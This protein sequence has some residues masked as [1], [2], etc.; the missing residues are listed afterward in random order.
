AGKWELFAEAD[1]DRKQYTHLKYP[2]FNVNMKDTFGWG[3]GDLKVEGYIQGKLAATRFFSGQGADKKF[4]LKPDD[5]ELIADGADAT[6]VVLRVTDEFGNI[7]PLANDPIIFALEGPA[8]LIGDNPFGL[9][10]GTGAVWVRAKETPGV[11][12]LTAKHPRL[13]ITTISF[14]VRDGH[15]DGA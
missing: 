7:R 12:R 2:P 14:V 15:P 5:V 3:W 9:V 11:V 6:R 13:G 1:P 8:E 10:G 4:E